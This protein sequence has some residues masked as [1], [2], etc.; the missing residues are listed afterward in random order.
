LA[1]S[2]AGNILVSS[3]AGNILA[4]SNAGNILAS[5]KAGNILA[6]SPYRCFH[7]QISPT[8]KIRMGEISMQYFTES[9]ILHFSHGRLYFVSVEPVELSR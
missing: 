6:S 5:S 8:L 7:W 4:S 9:T 2:D 1:S 3:D